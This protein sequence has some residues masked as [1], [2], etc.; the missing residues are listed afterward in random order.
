LQALRVAGNRIPM[1]TGDK[2]DEKYFEK[3]LRRR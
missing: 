1:D 2:G 3:Y